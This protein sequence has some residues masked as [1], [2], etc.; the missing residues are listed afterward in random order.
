MERMK[1]SCWPHGQAPLVLV[2]PRRTTCAPSSLR[3]TLFRPCAPVAPPRHKVSGPMK[4]EGREGDSRS[5]PPLRRHLRPRR[6]FC[7]AAPRGECAR[8]AGARLPPAVSAEPIG[9]KPS[10][11]HPPRGYEPLTS[12]R[13]DAR[14][15]SLGRTDEDE[16]SSNLVYLPCG[17]CKRVRGTQDNGVQGPCH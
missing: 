10:L 17:T 12:P 16:W 6:L 14:D 9:H 7:S 8:R 1:R 2:P 3:P 13:A 15:L 4:R 5:P 11:G